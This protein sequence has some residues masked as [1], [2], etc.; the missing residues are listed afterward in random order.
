MHKWAHI[1]SQLDNITIVFKEK[2]IDI[3]YLLFLNIND[4]LSLRNLFRRFSYFLK[5]FV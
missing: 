2:L 4:V 1:S 3:I 5:L